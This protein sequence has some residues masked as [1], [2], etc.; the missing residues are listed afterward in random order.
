MSYLLSL[1]PRG[2]RR[3]AL[4]CSAL[5]FAA[6]ACNPD[7][8]TAPATDPVAAAPVETPAVTPAAPTVDLRSPR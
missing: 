1:A 3:R 8:S 5:V 4:A 7:E 2:A 6:V